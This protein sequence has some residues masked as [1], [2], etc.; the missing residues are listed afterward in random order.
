MS[1]LSPYTTLCRSGR[2]YSSPEHYD[3][4]LCIGFRACTTRL[5]R[6]TLGLLTA[7]SLWAG[8]RDVR[9]LAL[10][11]VPVLLLWLLLNE[12]AR[13]RQRSWEAVEAAMT[14]RGA[15]PFVVEARASSHGA[16]AGTATTGVLDSTDRWKLGARKTATGE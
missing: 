11:V 14:A 3:Q 6:W 5:A 16:R 4:A 8:T 9:L 10:A 15:H 13:L 7:G 12:R 1:H 2:L